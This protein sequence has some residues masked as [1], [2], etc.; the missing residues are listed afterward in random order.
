VASAV[1]SNFLEAD[2]DTEQ[3]RKTFQNNTVLP[4]HILS[5]KEFI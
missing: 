3:K 4:A 5:A 1:R 2:L